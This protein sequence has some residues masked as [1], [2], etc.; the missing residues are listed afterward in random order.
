MNQLIRPAPRVLP[1]SLL[2]LAMASFQAGASIAKTM[3]PLVGALGM[4]TVRIVLG[5]AI[6]AITMKPW[7]ARIAPG[8]WR[9]LVIY[10]MSLG[11]MNLCF[12]IALSRIPLGIA[13][14]VEF[15]GPLAVAVF[16]S[17]RAL[18]FCWV[19]L[20]IGGLLLLLPIAH[21]GSRLD[22]VGMLYALGA[23]ACWAVYIIFGRKA[24]AVHGAQT[25]ALGSVI[26]TILIAPI[27]LA[28]A[29]S[30]LFSRSVLLPGLAVAILSTAL[31][32]TL[33]MIALTR[34]PARTFG[35]LMSVD[36]ALAAFFGLVFLNERL[37]G[38]Q[39]VAIILIIGASIGTT[40]A[41]QEKVP[42]PG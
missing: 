30:A 4:V 24:G 26:S 29:G 9:A 41:V 33:E 37:S 38:M 5:T 23:G 1:I 22:P 34:I 27:G 18:D 14:A 7:R 40:V 42:M 12:Y 21:Q 10:G 28:T 13:V 39:W 19:V 31:P 17:R 15:S 25:V 36:P 35:I 11:L 32:Y 6:L 2:V 16:T 8:S 20:A 3:F